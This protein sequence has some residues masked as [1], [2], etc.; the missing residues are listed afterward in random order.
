MDAGRKT[1]DKLHL[2]LSLLAGENVPR[3]QLWEQVSEF[4]DPRTLTVEQAVENYPVVAKAFKHWDPNRD[5]PEE[6]MER[7]CGGTPDG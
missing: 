6:I 7:L 2:E 1:F 4:T 5:T 3:M